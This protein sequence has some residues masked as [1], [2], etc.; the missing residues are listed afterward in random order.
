MEK[1]KLK[2]NKKQLVLALFIAGA[3]LILF[4]IIMLAVVVPQGRPGFFKIWLLLAAYV[5]SHDA[6]SHFFRY[7][8][9][10]RRNIPTKELTGERVIRRMSLYLRNMVGKDDYLPEVWERNYFRETDKEFG[11]NRV[12]APLVA[13]K[14][15]YDLASVDQDDCWK[16]FV[17]ADASLIYDISDE[18]RR[19][20]EQRMPQALEEIYSDA[21]GKY[22][23][24]IKDFLVGNKRY[25]KRRML[26]Y[27][28]KNDGAFY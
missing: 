10:T 2:L 27:A 25:M 17:Q 20:G 18:L 28:L 19:A 4:D 12:L 22:I 8:E 23:E 5:H 24:N 1:L 6:D 7:D 9:E 16:L 14:M 13:Y 21:E 11:E 3:V 26:E 15:L